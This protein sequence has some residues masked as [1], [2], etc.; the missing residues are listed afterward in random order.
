LA[1]YLASQISRVFGTN[2]P[3]SLVFQEPTIDAMARRLRTRVDAAL[4]IAA[5][6]E[7][8]SLMP[9]FCGG[10]MRE[11]LDLSRALGS[12]QPFFQLDVFAL[13]QQRLPRRPVPAR[14]PLHP[15]AWPLFS[16]RHV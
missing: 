12:N 7:D 5:L 11:F 6:Q 1:V 3:V 10:S 15:A 4:S 2:F 13:Q 9:F 16:R 14:H 8:G